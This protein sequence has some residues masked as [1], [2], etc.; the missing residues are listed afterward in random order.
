[1][2]RTLF[3]FIS[4][5]LTLVMAGCA[6][7]VTPRTFISQDKEQTAIDTTGLHDAANQDELMLGITRVK[8][9][10]SHGQLLRGIAVSYPDA[11]ANIVIYPGNGMTISKANK[12]IHRFSKVPA[13]LL[14]V[15]YQG[16]GASEK[17]PEISIDSLKEDA[18][19]VFD[20]ARDVFHNSNPILVHGVSMGSLIAPYVASQR[21]VDGLVLDGAIDS[22]PELVDNLVPVW[23][24]LF[25]RVSVSDELN[26]ID[27]RDNIRHY[28][29]PLLILAGEEDDTTPVAASETLFA[30]SPSTNKQLI[31]IPE[32][33][34]AMAMK[35]DMT[36]EAY[37]S[38]IQSL[39]ARENHAE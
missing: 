28:D 32:A 5:S 26:S 24:K 22:V 39:T 20:H 8:L 7:D 35:Y 30:V 10:N 14:I 19:L 2:F 18:V 33:T 36:I 3:I 1:M 25:T 21:Q 23:S 12:F 38:F 16:M 17:A 31:R 27:N 37:Q 15:D 29:G 13:N 34:H 6:V 4:L 9:V 11:I